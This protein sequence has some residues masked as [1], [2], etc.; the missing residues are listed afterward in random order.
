MRFD[1]VPE[2][3]HYIIIGAA[4]LTIIFGRQDYKSTC[5]SY[6]ATDLLPVGEKMSNGKY[7]GALVFE[8]FDS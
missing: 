1:L 4:K 5:L 6:Q 2:R 8:L 7:L 3:A